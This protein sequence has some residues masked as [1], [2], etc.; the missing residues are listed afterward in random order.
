MLVKYRSTGKRGHDGKNA[1]WLHER[2]NSLTDGERD[3]EE[4][5]KRGH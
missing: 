3:D 2:V 1:S 4:E 5:L